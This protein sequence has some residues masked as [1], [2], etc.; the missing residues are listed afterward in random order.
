MKCKFP[1]CDNPH[2]CLGYCKTHDG[3]FRRTGRRW[4]IGTHGPSGVYDERTRDKRRK[5]LHD[6]HYRDG[7][8]IDPDGYL[9]WYIY[10]QDDPYKGRQVYA[11]RY[12]MELYLGHELDEDQIVHHIDGDRLNNHLSN[13]EVLSRSEHARIHHEWRRNAVQ[14]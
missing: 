6:L 11:H 3:Q 7:T 12:L 9:R 1:G 4:A 2:S 14:G 10:D 8:Y 13:L 5:R